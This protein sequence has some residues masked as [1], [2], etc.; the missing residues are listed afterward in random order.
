[1][2][3]AICLANVCV[4]ASFRDDFFCTAVEMKVVSSCS[5]IIEVVAIAHFFTLNRS[6]HQSSENPDARSDT[7]G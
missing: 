1:M 4:E 6:R 2:C 5:G 7:I 3:S